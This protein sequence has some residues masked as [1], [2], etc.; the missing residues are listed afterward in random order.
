M[1]IQRQG[2][3]R[4]RW[5]ENDVGYEIQSASGSRCRLWQGKTERAL[6]MS[7]KADPNCL[8]LSTMSDTLYI[9]KISYINITKWIMDMCLRT[10]NQFGWYWKLYV[11]TTLLWEKKSFDTEL[12]RSLNVILVYLC[13]YINPLWGRQRGVKCL[14]VVLVREYFDPNIFI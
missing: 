7:W 6:N 10:I 13:K 11:G 1:D 8:I 9:P 14:Q 2:H 4:A 12:E 5:K 3:F